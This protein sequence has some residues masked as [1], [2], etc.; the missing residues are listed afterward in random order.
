MV[1]LESGLD[2]DVSDLDTIFD[3]DLDDDAKKFW[4]NVAYDFLDNRLDWSQFSTSEKKRMEAVGA[5]DAASSQDPRIYRETVGD[6]DFR[7]QRDPNDTDYWNWLV[8]L[9]HTGKLPTEKGAPGVEFETFG[10]G[11]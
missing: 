3:S 4:L 9:D 5:A 7:Y 2:A 6:A 11:R 10:P 1:T 8:N